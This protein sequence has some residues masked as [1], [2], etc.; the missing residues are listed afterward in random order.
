MFLLFFSHGVGFLKYRFV[1]TLI[2]FFRFGTCGNPRVVAS[3]LSA[4]PVG[5][6]AVIRP[7]QPVYSQSTATSGYVGTIFPVNVQVS[8]FHFFFRRDAD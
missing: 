3:R 1:Q 2:V 8:Y 6:P 7:T 4:L 5:P